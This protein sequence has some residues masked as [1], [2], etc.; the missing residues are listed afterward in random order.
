MIDLPRGRLYCRPA[1]PLGQN[2][3]LQYCTLALAPIVALPDSTN[4]LP[5]YIRVARPSETWS[6]VSNPTGRAGVWPC[7]SHPVAVLFSILPH[8]AKPA[9]MLSFKRSAWKDFHL[10][11]E[12]TLIPQKIKKMDYTIK[13]QIHQFA[14]LN[15]FGDVCEHTGVQHQKRGPMIILIYTLVN[16]ACLCT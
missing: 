5:L 9:Q 4:M 15:Y 14:P 12:N 6:A 1:W 13:V 8:S 11:R 2:G 16:Y 3:P 10:K 7:I